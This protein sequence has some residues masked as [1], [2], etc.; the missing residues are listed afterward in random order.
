[1]DDAMQVRC[2]V[3]AATTTNLNYFLWVEIF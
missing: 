1:M 3:Y 2:G